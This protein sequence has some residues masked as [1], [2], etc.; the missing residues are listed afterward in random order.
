MGLKDGQWLCERLSRSGGR[1]RGEPMYLLSSMSKQSGKL[2]TSWYSILDGTWQPKSSVLFTKCMMFAICGHGISLARRVYTVT[3]SMMEIYCEQLNDLLDGNKYNLEVQ[4]APVKHG[5][6]L[7]TML[8]K[9]LSEIKVANAEAAM[10]LF[11]K[12]Q[13][14]RKVSDGRGMPGSA[15]AIHKGFLGDS[16]HC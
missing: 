13:E 4:E 6:A 2:S 15:C 14:I 12:G 3:L 10:A 16:G 8:V 1:Y 5:S 7:T 11:R 9:G